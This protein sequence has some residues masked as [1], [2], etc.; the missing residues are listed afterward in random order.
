[1]LEQYKNENNDLKKENEYYKNKSDDFKKE[2]DQISK[3]KHKLTTLI[4]SHN[5][6]LENLL[7]KMNTN[8]L[9]K[10]LGD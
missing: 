6:K 10:L 7:S 1:M 3:E 4:N 8:D 9:K 5:E 2:N